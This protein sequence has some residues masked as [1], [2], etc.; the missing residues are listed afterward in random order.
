M[1]ETR[2]EKI[3]AHVAVI[4]DGNGRWATRRMKNRIFGH[5]NAIE[6]VRATVEYAVETGVKFLT[7]YT[8]SE[9]N[10]QRPAMEVEGLMALLADA[11]RNETPTLLKNGVRLQCIGHRDALPTGVQ[12]KLQECID[13]TAA[14]RAMTLILAL[15]YSGKWDLTEAFK[16][17][18]ADVA[19]GRRR[20]SDCSPAV[21]DDYLATAGIPVPDLLI[22]T[23]GEQRIS[24]F[25]LWQMAYT[26][27]YFTDVLWPDFRKPHFREALQEYNRRERRYGKTSE[28]IERRRRKEKNKRPQKAGA[29]IDENV[30]E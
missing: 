11:I 26:E 20:L 3:P 22:R 17:Y 30:E 6:A 27:L 5:R 10:W 12:A 7:L 18:A 2:P 28:Q 14:G 19:Q 23:G 25:M 16:R 1:P 13:R 21:V 8:F 9:E 15:S 24:N 29:A 4:M